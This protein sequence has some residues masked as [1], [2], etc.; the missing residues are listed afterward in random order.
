MLAGLGRVEQAKE[1]YRRSL[2]MFRECDD[3]EN[4]KFY[5]MELKAL[6]RGSATYLG[7]RPEGIPPDLRKAVLKRLETE[8]PDRYRDLE[9]QA[10]AT[11]RLMS[12]M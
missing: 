3:R 8:R 4:L 1:E 10:P 9:Q 12:G 6:E 5:G 11:V 2:Q 7:V